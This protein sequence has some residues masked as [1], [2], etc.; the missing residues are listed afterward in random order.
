MYKCRDCDY[1]S[2]ELEAIVDVE[3]GE[4]FSC[5]SNDIRCFDYDQYLEDLEQSVIEDQCDDRRKY[6]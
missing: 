2:E 5:G 4:C 1:M 6:D 3:T